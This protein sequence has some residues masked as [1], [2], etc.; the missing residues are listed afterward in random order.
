[1]IQSKVAIGSGSLLG[2]G[3]LQGT[4]TRLSFLPEQH[5]D[6]IFSVL[7]E[8]FGLIGCAIVI[9][10]FL[11][12]IIRGFLSTQIIR[13]PF[14][15]LM[16][17]GSVSILAFHVFVNIAMTIGMMPVTG[18]PLPFLSYGGS[19]TLTIAILVGFLLNAQVSGRE[20]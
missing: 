18:L 10:L 15:N 4:Q 1:M 8:Q 9:F 11:F 12:L 19:F 20:I 2:K 13:N 7:G 17:I 6:F 5:T 14:T 16:V 3:Y